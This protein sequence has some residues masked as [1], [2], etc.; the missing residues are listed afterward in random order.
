M[1]GRSV[2]DFECGLEGVSFRCVSLGSVLRIIHQVLVPL[3]HWLIL[4]A[5]SQLV[6]LT[7][8]VFP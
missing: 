4:S 6:G 1:Y 5:G 7:H 8:S 2:C 3:V